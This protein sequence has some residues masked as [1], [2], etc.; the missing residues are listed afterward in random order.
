MNKDEKMLEFLFTCPTIQENPLF[1]NFGN[2]EDNSNIVIPNSDDKALQKPYID[3][4]V[5]KRY[6]F[7]IDSFKSVAYNPIVQGE[8]DENVE[9]FS[10]VTEIANWV[11]AQ[12][13]I[14]NYPDFGSDCIIEKMETITDKPAFIGV[15]NSTNPPVAI[16][17]VT[18]QIDYIDM[19][20]VIWK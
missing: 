6:T 7:N 12:G 9:D 20:K 1:F 14:S 11:N 2:V 16:Y 10:D 5:A 18:I 4:S 13:E 8:S 17:R 15:D 19:S 3:G